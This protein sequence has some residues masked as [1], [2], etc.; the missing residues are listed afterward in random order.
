M[1]TYVDRLLQEQMQQAEQF[2]RPQGI[3]LRQYSVFRQLPGQENVD[4]TTDAPTGPAFD[5]A[6]SDNRI[7]KESVEAQGVEAL[8]NRFDRLQAANMRAQS[9]QLL[10]KEAFAQSAGAVSGIAG[11][12]AGSVQEQTVSGTFSQVLLS[13]GM[14]AQPTARSMQEISRF[15]ERDARRY[16]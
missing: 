11:V 3:E 15:F 14:A 9:V 2:S 8:L 4:A 7:P 12:R 10:T 1:Q 13:G 5:E 6:S 16:G